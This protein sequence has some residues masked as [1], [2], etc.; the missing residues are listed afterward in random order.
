MNSPFSYFNKNN[1]SNQINSE[2]LQSLD[3]N[4]LTHSNDTLADSVSIINKTC[5]E[6]DNSFKLLEISSQT[7]TKMKDFERSIKKQID[8]SKDNFSNIFNNLNKELKAIKSQ[9]IDNTESYIKFASNF[10]KSA[11]AAKEEINKEETRTLTES[12]SILLDLLKSVLEDKEASNISTEKSTQEVLKHTT[13]SASKVKK[14]FSRNKNNS[15]QTVDI[16]NNVTPA[17][18]IKDLDLEIAKTNSTEEASDVLNKADVVANKDNI[19]EVSRL[20]TFNDIDDSL[21][22]N[23]SESSETDGEKNNKNN[24]YLIRMT[25]SF[26]KKHKKNETSKIDKLT[27]TL[28]KN[29]QEKN[30]INYN[31][32]NQDKD[33]VSDLKKDYDLVVAELGEA[34]DKASEKKQTSDSNVLPSEVVKHVKKTKSD[35]SFFSRIAKSFNKSKNIDDDNKSITSTES[36]DSIDS[37]ISVDINKKDELKV[38]NGTLDLNAYLG[39]NKKIVGTQLAITKI[40]FP[41]IQNIE[42]GE[43]TDGFF[44]ISPFTQTG[45]N[46]VELKLNDSTS[47]M[48]NIFTDSDYK[49]ASKKSKSHKNKMYSIVQTVN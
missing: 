26:I 36:I 8:L 6:D 29:N 49:K 18:E 42:T 31:Q 30:G 48:T 5:R 44:T 41:L 4:H 25:K 45:K 22:V 24:S 15:A 34:L 35:A 43:I 27:T 47:G 33:N 28:K 14:I 1:E 38:I 23:G 39:N 19:K 40:V 32:E 37:G 7:S 20:I 12:S 16:K 17:I 13:P 11:E 3:K 9:K 21:S 2:T 10:V 46:W